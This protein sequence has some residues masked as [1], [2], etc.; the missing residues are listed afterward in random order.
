[1]FEQLLVAFKYNFSERQL[2]YCV[3]LTQLTYLLKRR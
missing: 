1:M 2:L 3:K